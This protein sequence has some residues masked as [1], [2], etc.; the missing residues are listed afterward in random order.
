MSKEWPTQPDGPRLPSGPYRQSPS[1]PQP[2][3]QTFIRQDHHL[4]M[5]GQAAGLTNDAF[6]RKRRWDDFGQATMAI[7]QK[8]FDR[9]QPDRGIRIRNALAAF[10]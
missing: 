6:V 5:L 8:P 9:R 7:L 1:E 4:I 3:A 10:G 2:L